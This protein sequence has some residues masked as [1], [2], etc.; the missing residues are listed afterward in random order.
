[1][2][3]KM[4]GIYYGNQRAETGENISVVACVFALIPFPVGKEVL[5]G[6]VK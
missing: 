2:Q 1:M 4:A 6:H 3:K 5:H